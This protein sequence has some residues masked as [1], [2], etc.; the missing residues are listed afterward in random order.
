MVIFSRPD[1]YCA[2][3]ILFWGYGFDNGVEKTNISFNNNYVYN[4]KRIYFICDQQNT[5]ILFQKEN[6]IRWDFN[7]YY[8]TN[9]SFI[10]RGIYKFP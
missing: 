9:D 3:H 4:P 10:Y 7:H 2:S 1:Q 5:Y 6:C 8:L